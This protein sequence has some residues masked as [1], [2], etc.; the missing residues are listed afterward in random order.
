MTPEGG[1]ETEVILSILRDIDSKV[2]GLTD[3]YRKFRETYVVSHERVV[4]QADAAH[5]RLDRLEPVVDVLRSCQERSNL[6]IE[7]LAARI[8]ILVWVMGLIGAA[9]IAWITEQILSGL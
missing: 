4:N 9:A 6:A 5:R 7:K 2:D 3:D 8:S 1:K